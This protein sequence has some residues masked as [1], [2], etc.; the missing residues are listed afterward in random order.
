MKSDRLGFRGWRH[1]SIGLRICNWLEFGN[2][3]DGSKP[4]CAADLGKLKKK[5]KKAN[6]EILATLYNMK[7]EQ[8]VLCFTGYPALA[9]S[10][11]P[12]WTYLLHGTDSLGT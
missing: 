6:K 4:Q 9:G 1:L 10:F 7:L 12:L 5:K 2:V 8:L 11:I 3:V